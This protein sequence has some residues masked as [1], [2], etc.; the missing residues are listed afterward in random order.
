M[1]YYYIYYLLYYIIFIIFIYNMNKMP[2][3]IINALKY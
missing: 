2:F 3:I 1:S